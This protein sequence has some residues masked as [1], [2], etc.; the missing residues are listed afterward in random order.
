MA[1]CSNT[2]MVHFQHHRATRSPVKM[3]GGKRMGATFRLL[4]AGKKCRGRGSLFDVSAK[5][6]HLRA[7]EPLVTVKRRNQR[8][9]MTGKTSRPSTR[10]I[11]RAKGQKALLVGAAVAGRSLGF[12]QRQMN[13]T[14]EALR[15]I[16]V[17]E[18]NL[19]NRTR[20]DSVD[21]FQGR[22]YRI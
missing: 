6:V 15:S 3:A 13:Q 19:I 20:P 5:C 11:I 17:E 10:E 9:V 7:F 4:L 8:I 21:V 18:G 14:H 12:L 2:N 1:F 16:A 22:L